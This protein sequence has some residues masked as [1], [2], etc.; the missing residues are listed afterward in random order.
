MSTFVNTVETVGDK[1]LTDSIID[2]SITELNCNITTSIRQQA[3]RACDAL[4][5]VS[6][7]SVT[8][9]AL[10]AFW[11]CAA[12]KRAE[13]GSAAAFANNS[14]YGCSA[15]TALILRSTEAICTASGTPFA[16]GCAIG[17]G[18]GYIYVPRALVDTY[19]AASGWSTYAAQ[20]RAI[21]DYPGAT[22]PYTWE[23]VFANID[24][25]SYADVYEVGDMVELD[26]GSE[27]VVNMQIAGIDADDL[28]NGSGKA[29][30]SWIS[31]EL[32]ATL[33]RMNPTLVKND[34]GSYQEGTGNIGG[35]EKS[36]M[37]SYLKDTIKP[38]IPENVRG[39][40]VEVSKRQNALNTS[41]AYVD[42]TTTDDVWIP[43]GD[44]EVN[45][46]VY[47]ELFPDN[48]SRIKQRLHSN[49]GW[50]LRGAIKYSNNKE[51]FCIVNSNG[52]ITGSIS[53][54]GATTASGIA[55]GFC[56]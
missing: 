52:S 10:G 9:I 8:S 28:A 53:G 55:L 44:Y 36:E 23:G 51:C 22:D 26:L 25:G 40:I 1:A 32:L 38:L 31:K 56:T 15:L 42:Q 50:W 4:K 17:N 49:W 39:R 29:P 43:N 33:H 7:P 46:G 27:G 45:Y 41:G 34:D 54:N 37:R 20:I 16:G 47:T 48:A 14:F 30:I 6:F 3:F 21:E 24:D 2:R 19:K 12:L 11:G 18:T 35:W 13:F 5:K